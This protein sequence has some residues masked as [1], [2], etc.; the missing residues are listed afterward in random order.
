MLLE[1]EAILRLLLESER[2][3]GSPDEETGKF[4]FRGAL[5][6]ATVFR[7]IKGNFKVWGA[8]LTTKEVMTLVA[9]AKLLSPAWSAANLTTPA[10]VMESM[11]PFK[12]A[13]PESNETL[14][15][16]PEE[17]RGTCIGT[18]RLEAY[19]RFVRFEKPAIDWA[20]RMTNENWFVAAP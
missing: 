8:W 7:A 12:I 18:N 10:F 11:V 13:G 9:G 14:T 4:S 19:V 6:N 2:A 3:T 16:N 1:I 20:L 15:A 5:V 17:D